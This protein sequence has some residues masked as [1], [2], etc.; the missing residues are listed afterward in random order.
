VLWNYLR[1][2]LAFFIPAARELWFVEVV[3]LV[4]FRT[5]RANWSA[6][7]AKWN[8]EFYESAYLLK[9]SN[10]SLVSALRLHN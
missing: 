10:N 8:T 3:A 1:E 5:C 2:F 6:N 7:V 4:A 9:Q